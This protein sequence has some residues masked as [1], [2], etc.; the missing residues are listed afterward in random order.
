MTTWPK[1]LAEGNCRWG[2]T[3]TGST[4][5]RKAQECT[6]A[7][8]S[9]LR[10]AI[11]A[12]SRS[13]RYTRNPNRA[14]DLGLFFT[15]NNRLLQTL[16]I[17]RIAQ[18]FFTT[19]TLETS[20]ALFCSVL[21]QHIPSWVQVIKDFKAVLHGRVVTRSSLEQWVKHWL[22]KHEDASLDSQHPGQKKT[23]LCPL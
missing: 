7:P 15:G 21:T 2:Q 4:S 19:I 6:F 18:R 22:C 5:A 20:P 8:A 17:V 1:G 10:N 13:P 16:I 14:L 23:R 11:P 12:P 3:A 9:L